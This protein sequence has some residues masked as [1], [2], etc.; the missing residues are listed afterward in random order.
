M[1]DA[2]FLIVQIHPDADERLSASLQTLGARIESS[3]GSIL[4]CKGSPDVEALEPGSIAY[5]SLISEWPDSQALDE[6]WSGA[7]KEQEFAPLLGG[8][9]VRILA[10]ASLPKE[11][12]PGEAV[13]TIATVP[14]S[15][16]SGPLGYLIVDG[17]AYDADRL[18]AY[19]DILFDLMIERH[20]YYI[21]LTDATGVRVLSGEWDE[22]I[23]A[24]SRW[25]N[26]ELARDFWYSDRYQKEAIPIRTGAGHFTVTIQEGRKP[27]S[28]DG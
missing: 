21:A 22:Q 23:Y 18:S 5:A 28:A 14:D 12:W 2:E 17:E 13:P 4:S 24:I 1:A 16:L 25:P 8:D 19:Q 15:G 9:G 6:F 11:G 20:S 3:A 7:K 10:V 26:M 27:E